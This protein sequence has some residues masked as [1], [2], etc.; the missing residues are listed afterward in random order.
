MSSVARV[1]EI[2]GR[3]ETSFDDAIETGVKRASETLRNVTGAWV[4]EKEL[5]LD[6]GSITAYK[7][8]LHVTFV[9][10]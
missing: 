4:K 9:L 2:I 7:V 3:S 10:E 6:N 8:K 1:T 5:D